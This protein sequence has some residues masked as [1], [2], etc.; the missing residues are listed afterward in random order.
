MPGYSFSVDTVANARLIAAA[1][2]LLDAC[3]ALFRVLN[4]NYIGGTPDDDLDE[5]VQ[6]TLN[7]YY[8]AT[9]KAEGR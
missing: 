8:A 6:E 2:D 4:D 7:L 3:H 9:E 1:P 5:R